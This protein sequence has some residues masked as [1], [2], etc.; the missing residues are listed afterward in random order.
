MAMR[1]VDHDEIG[2]GIDQPLGAGKAFIAD[3]RR[4]RHAQA[5]LLVLAGMGMDPR[6]LDVLHRD[7][8]DAAILVV[9]HEQLLDAMLM[10]QALGFLHADGF[11]DGDE[12]LLG[13]QLVDR[14]VRIGGEAHV[15]V[16]EDADEL[17][18]AAAVLRRLHHRDAGDLMVGHQ[19]QRFGKARAW[20]GW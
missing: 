17:A 8:A 10:Q 12:P 16:G 2:A 14:L 19:L 1:G 9:D 18:V 13:H 11:A 15:A 7:Q 20:D 3:A 5:P 6:L 4:R